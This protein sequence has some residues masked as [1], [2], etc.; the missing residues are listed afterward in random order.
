MNK[1]SKQGIV[2]GISIGVAGVIIGVG[3]YFYGLLKYLKDINENVPRLDDRP[4]LSR[5]ADIRP[6]KI[7]NGEVIEGRRYLD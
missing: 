2:I 5:V 1:K 7:V 3:Y 4:K 6:I